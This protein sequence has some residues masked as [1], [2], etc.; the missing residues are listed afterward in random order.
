MVSLEAVVVAG[1]ITIIDEGGTRQGRLSL[2]NI[3]YSSLN[4]EELIRK[5]VAGDKN[6]YGAIYIRYQKPLQH[7]AM[8]YVH[9]VTAAEDIVQDAFIRLR[10][11][12]GEYAGNGPIKLSNLLHTIV[13][14]L[15]LNYLRDN[16][17]CNHL[18][19]DEG[20]DGIFP[21]HDHVDDRIGIK[22]GVADALDDPRL[23]GIYKEILQLRFFEDL[24]YYDIAIKL[25]IPTGTVMSR[26]YRAR[27]LLAR[28]HPELKEY[29]TY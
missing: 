3:N 27:W 22:V 24:G 10:P 1:D 20:I 2:D 25:R 7:Y 16:N 28:L 8:K 11:K 12:L 13:N 9:D 19:F 4:D 17:G 29:L 6:A 18:S 5:T 26:L 15:C 21:H 14:R 23:S